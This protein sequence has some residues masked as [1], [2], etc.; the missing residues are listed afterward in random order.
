VYSG[1]Q[2]L[3]RRRDVLASLY[4][5][6]TLSSFFEFQMP[7]WGATVDDDGPIARIAVRD[8]LLEAIPRMAFGAPA[9][10]VTVLA[11]DVKSIEAAALRL[12]ELSPYSIGLTT[13][14]RALNMLNGSWR[15][16]YSDAPEITNL[17]ILPLGFQLGEVYQPIDISDRVLEN[18]ASVKHSLGLATGSTRVVGSF[19]P[20]P[21]GTTN[22][23]GVVNRAGNRIDVDFERVVFSLDEFLAVSLGGRVR[24]IVAP[25]PDPAAPQPAVDITY[26][27]ERIR[28]TRGGDGSLFVLVREASP[29]KLLDAAAKAALRLEAGEAAVTGAALSERSGLP[30]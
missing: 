16:V 27:D 17:A 1:E 18:Q 28:I 6:S 23:A 24:K 21:L 15:L 8:A 9:T 13:S 14:D 30:S 22:A 29:T 26:L 12:E 3:L 11:R 2:L 19:R 5:G 25:Q 10:N 7:A 20:A 4:I